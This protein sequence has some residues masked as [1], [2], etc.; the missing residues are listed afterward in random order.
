MHSSLD[1]L[2][3]TCEPNFT[4]TTNTCLWTCWLRKLT[5]FWWWRNTLLRHRWWSSTSNTRSSERR[6]SPRLEVPFPTTGRVGGVVLPLV[7]QVW[8]SVVSG[9]TT[10]FVSTVNAMVQLPGILN[11]TAGSSDDRCRR[12]RAIYLATVQGNTRPRNRL[13]CRDKRIR[14]QFLI[15]TG[16]EVSIIK[17][18]FEERLKPDLDHYA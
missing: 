10:R 4:M 8:A 15:N 16:N 18:K 17:L 6:I 5:L 2:I 9:K 12:G 13:F 11:R 1:V 7:P 3:S 14:V